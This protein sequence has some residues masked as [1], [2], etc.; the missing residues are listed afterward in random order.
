M[1]FL[2]GYIMK[3]RF[4]A[5]TVA[6]S[7]ALLALLFPPVS[8]VSSASVALVT[9]RRGA[10]EGLWVLIASCVAAAILGMFLPI[11][12]HIALLYG[13]VIWLPVW[14][15]AIVLREGRQLAVTIEITVILG[16]LGVIGFYLYHPAPAAL[17]NNVLNVMFQPMLTQPGVPAEEI[18]QSLVRFSR[19]MTGAIAAGIVY[20]VLFGLFLARWWQAVLYNPGGFRSEFLSLRLHPQLALATLV[21]VAMALALSGKVAEA[22]WNVIV[23]LFVLYTIT[24]TAALH[25]AFAKAKSGRFMV[26]FLY[27]TLV[28]IPHVAIAV[29]LFGLGDTWLDLRNKISNQTDTK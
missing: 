8:I 3:G 23:L 12:S 24:G 9:L 27:I 25:D 2:A 6:S 17:W 22:C 26:P 10:G 5:T 28:M 4:Q 15:I 20:G 1:K 13:L 29:A 11:G 16:V 7:L 19:L 21:V 14:L 18:T